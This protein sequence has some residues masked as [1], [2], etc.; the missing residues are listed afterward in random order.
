[1]R[2]WLAVCAVSALAQLS[3]AA[4]D[5]TAKLPKVVSGAYEITSPEELI[6]YAKA[7]VMRQAINQ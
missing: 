6:G 3:F 4:W 2:K 5:G 7:E 1:M